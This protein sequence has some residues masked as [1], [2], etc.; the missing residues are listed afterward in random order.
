[1]KNQPMNQNKPVNKW[2]SSDQEI[3][4]KKKNS[5]PLVFSCHYQLFVIR[6]KYILTCTSLIA[7]FGK[8]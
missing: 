5:L 7:H 2:T 3:L 4:K 1:M 6:Y 8:E